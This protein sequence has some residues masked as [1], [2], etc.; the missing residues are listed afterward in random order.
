MVAIERMS[1]WLKDRRL[2]DRYFSGD[3]IDYVLSRGKGAAASL[4]ARFAAKEA[5]GKAM[6]SGLKG[7]ALKDIRVKNGDYGRPELIISGTAEEAF[8]LLGGVRAHLSLTHDA[9]LAVAQVIIEG[10]DY[11]RG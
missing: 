2:L 1:T 3:E 8:R 4:A 9:S 5:F 6:G 11:G 10:E 7:I